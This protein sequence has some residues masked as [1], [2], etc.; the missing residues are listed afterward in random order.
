ME[1][2]EELDNLNFSKCRD[3]SRAGQGDSGCTRF[4]SKTHYFLVPFMYFV[5]HHSPPWVA[6]KCTKPAQFFSGMAALT[7]PVVKIIAQC[8]GNT[9]NT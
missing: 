2:Q 5:Q 1:L 4:L 3:V 6:T 7:V 8:A 9:P